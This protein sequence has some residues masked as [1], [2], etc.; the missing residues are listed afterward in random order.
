MKR[1]I[2]FIFLVTMILV[3][4]LALA[5]SEEMT[6]MEVNYQKTEH[7]FIIS[8]GTTTANFVEAGGSG[9]NEE[10]VYYLK[11]LEENGNRKYYALTGEGELVKVIEKTLWAYADEDDFS[12]A[13]IDKAYLIP[14]DP[15]I[16]SIYGGEVGP[17]GEKVYWASQE[18]NFYALNAGGL[19]R[20]VPTD[21]EYV[22]SDK[23]GNTVSSIGEAY[24][25]S[26]A[27]GNPII[28]P[29]E[30]EGIVTLGSG[31]K[32]LHIGDSHTVG[33]Y[34]LEMDRLLRNTGATVE[35]FGVGGAS[36]YT[37]DLGTYNGILSGEQ[38]RIFIDTNN[39]KSVPTRDPS[40]QQL[41][42]EFNPNMI[43]ISLGTNLINGNSISYIPNLVEKATTSGATCYWVGPPAATSSSVKDKIPSVINQLQG[44]VSP[45]TFIDSTPYSDVSLID[46]DGVHY[47]SEGGKK[48]AQGVFQ[49]I[50]PSSTSAGNGGASKGTPSAATVESLS[51]GATSSTLPACLTSACKEVDSVWISI[52]SLID[53]P[54]K[55][56]V[57]DPKLRWQTQLTGAV[58]APQ[59][60]SGVSSAITSPLVT[61]PA[62][63]L[64]ED[65]Q[66]KSD[67]SQGLYDTNFLNKV[68][69]ICKDL[70]INPL[71]LMAVMSF[72]TVHTFSPS[73][74]NP[75]SSA[76]GLI[77]FMEETA[78][79]MGTTTAQLAQM[80]QV[81][82]LDYVKLYFQKK[83]GIRPNDFGDV[84]MAVIWPRAIGQNEDYVLFVRGDGYYE[85]NRE[86]DTSGDG[87]VTR[88][89]Y[90][91]FVQKQG[92]GLS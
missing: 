92:Y 69:S 40:L 10:I 9:P 80:S 42:S 44:M 24:V 25:L 68:D 38:N 60:G 33:S 34:G 46:S 7:G 43:I 78:Q 83:I 11:G 55:G 74:K 5:A 14:F 61:L 31:V 85:P 20:I 35:T 12:V 26:N 22:Y 36:A 66:V 87:Q 56:K 90:A 62:G 28:I 3:S 50:N 30:E 73:I 64:Y 2:T 21:T 71:H 65:P 82:Q 91:S 23:N 8:S 84:A 17:N 1:K 77:Q 76:T 13:S 41:V 57:W 16:V 15:N 4:S 67:L 39:Q 89:E 6:G 54:Y 49:Q 63:S 45:C 88:A 18:K 86:L 70:G 53:T 48:W 58:T 51:S 19:V 72:E 59:G 32:V 81:Q 37:W 47:T 75:R 29:V 52:S 79:S 27:E